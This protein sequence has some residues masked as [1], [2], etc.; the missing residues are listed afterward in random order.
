MKFIDFENC[1]FGQIKFL[2][3]INNS[4]W[5]YVNI[6]DQPDKF[7][8]EIQEFKENVMLNWHPLKLAESLLSKIKQ[9]SSRHE[10][11]NIIFEVSLRKDKLLVASIAI[12]FLYCLFGIFL[13][14]VCTMIL[15]LIKLKQELY[16]RKNNSNEAC[17]KSISKKLLRFY[18]FDLLGPNK[19]KVNYSEAFL[20][21]YV[22]IDPLNR[23]AGIESVLVS[24]DS[25]RKKSGGSIFETP[26]FSL[27]SRVRHEETALLYFRMEICGLLIQK[28]GKK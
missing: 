7:W 5:S 17:D 21:Q 20:K 15:R 28:I 22:T 9:Y 12:K 24:G 23:V 13:P 10:I 16:D 6:H 25:S 3:I 27:V 2:V 19:T 14:E 26:I 18:T 8:V 1:L 4:I 11:H